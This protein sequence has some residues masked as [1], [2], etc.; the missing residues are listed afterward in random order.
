[1]SGWGERGRETG[2]SRTRSAAPADRLRV[3]AKR[4][5]FAW[6]ANMAW[7]RLTAATRRICECEWDAKCPVRFLEAKNLLLAVL[8]GRFVVVG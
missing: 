8:P 3:V 5:Q 7:R 1:M 4:R 6:P 2:K